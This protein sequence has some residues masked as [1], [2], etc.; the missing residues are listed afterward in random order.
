MMRSNTLRLFLL[1]ALALCLK[2]S[3][4][5]AQKV[6]DVVNNIPPA[7]SLNTSTNPAA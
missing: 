7:D 2:L 3:D 6:T 5:Q 4:I 1:T